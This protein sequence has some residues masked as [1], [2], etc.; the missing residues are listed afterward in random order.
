MIDEPA[1]APSMD[2]SPLQT[3]GEAAWARMAGR[4]ETLLEREREQ[5]PLWL[6]VAFGGGIA[7]W[8]VLPD[9]HA[10]IA[11]MLALGGIG[12][13]ALAADRGGRWSR[14][15][16][17]FAGAALLGLALVWMRAER[18]AAPVLARPTVARFAATILRQDR[19]PAR[20]SVRLLLAPVDTPA[21]PPRVRV[22]V[23]AADMPA[24]GP[25][26]LLSLRARIVPPPT[27]AVPDAY[28][29][30]RVAWFQRI[31]GTGKAIGR[32]TLLRPAEGG[33]RTRLDEWR[34][35]LSAH[36]QARL[37]GASGGIA[38]ALA[39]GDVGAI[40]ESDNEAMRR[41][42]LAHLL[43]VSGLHLT[44]VV[45]AVM[46]LTLRLLA[47]WPWLAL[48]APLVLIAAGTAAL[49]GVGYTLMTGAEVPTVR[50][51]IASLLVLG[52]IALG[53]DAM[54]LRLVAAGALA[55]L[56]VR[57][58]ALVGPSFQ[59]SF[60]AITAIVAFHDHP[61][62]RRLLARHE[63]GRGRALLRAMAG[64]LLTGL[65]VEVA[66][67]PIALFHFHR[68]GLYGAVANIVAI[69]LTTFVIM[70]LEAAA[71]LLDLGHLGAPLWWSAGKALA[72]LL[73]IA[74]AVAAAPGSVALMPA[75]PRGA[76]G[77]IAAGGLWCA[78]W[79]TPIRRWGTVPLAAGALW[80]ATA[81]AADLLV[82]GDGRHLAVRAPRGIAI[83][84][85]RAGDYVRDTL[86]ELAGTG[87]PAADLD[88]LPDARCNVDLCATDIM[89][90]G[91]RW[92]LLATRSRYPVAIAELVRACAAAD[93]VVS[94]RR[95]P[96]SCR[97][98][99]L[100]ADRVALAA[101]GGLAIDL[102]SGRV[103]T[104]ADQ[105]GAHPWVNAPAIVRGR[106]PGPPAAR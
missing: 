104:V 50:S 75:M 8:F 26:A 1:L 47:L 44:A 73:W 4:I 70:P 54:T 35:A 36:I 38:A 32:P 43:S 62:V 6:P 88:T 85:P 9:A 80:A 69:P 64:L 10:W 51:C 12:A 93:I 57:P 81:P 45:G 100:K 13:G 92:R 90:G 15:A 74:H 71:L 40:P 25:G 59:L 61:H 84:R 65:V 20:N 28:D 68:E 34:A 22:S 14:A 97:P 106:S 53:R 48:R 49:A 87:V 17:W 89:R 58:E 42:G 86:G 37:P 52:G 27:A 24:A 83:L 23:A 103:E 18:V 91:R 66:L 39:T 31:G 72:L 30:A 76:F 77:L 3:G 105:A 94:D 60:A 7:A 96:R 63:E 101:S 102:D 2:L 21:L 5:L 99:W 79:R 55:V 67:A 46:L 98:R 82:T 56:L 33:W 41:A 11:A 19:L 78:L 95:L 29:F 16:A